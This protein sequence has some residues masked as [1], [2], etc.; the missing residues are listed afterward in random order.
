[1]E[2]RVDCYDLRAH[3]GAGSALA[4]D[5]SRT[6]RAENGK[7]RAEFIL[8]QTR[9]VQHSA[10]ALRWG[11]LSIVVVTGGGGGLEDTKGRAM[12]YSTGVCW[13]VNDLPS[14]VDA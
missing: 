7:E 2:S 10:A 1:M 6:C 13:P 5:G 3:P 8:R 14:S 9:G 4:C 11:W 12:Q